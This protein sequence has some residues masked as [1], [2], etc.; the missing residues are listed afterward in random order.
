L[1]QSQLPVLYRQP[2]HFCSSLPSFVLFFCSSLLSCLL[3]IISFISYPI[4]SL[5]FLLIF[6]ASF[7][8]NSQFIASKYSSSLPQINSFLDAIGLPSFVF[9]MILLLYPLFFQSFDIHWLVFNL[10]FKL[11]QFLVV[12]TG[13]TITIVFI[14]IIVFLSL[15]LQLSR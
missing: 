2:P 13:I 11:S 12:V 15:F 1:F 5:L 7:R 9:T 10:V 4:A 3:V 6:Y 14:M 8:R